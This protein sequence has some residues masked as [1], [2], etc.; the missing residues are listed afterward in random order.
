M[1][2]LIHQALHIH[3]E[4]EI[5]WCQVRGVGGPC[6]WASTS[7]PPVAKGFIQILKDDIS[8]VC[9]GT[10]M[11]EPHFTMDFQQHHFQQFR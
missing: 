6:Y 8:D 11:L 7:I 10:I 2:C 5:Q 9:R 4:K 3:P 1:L